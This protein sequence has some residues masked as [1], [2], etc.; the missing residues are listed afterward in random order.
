MIAHFSHPPQPACCAIAQQDPGIW[1]LWRFF[2]P[3]NHTKR[4]YRNVTCKLLNLFEVWA[5]GSISKNSHIAWTTRP[6]FK[7][8]DVCTIRSGRSIYHNQS[9]SERLT[10][11]NTVTCTNNACKLLNLSLTI[12]HIWMMLNTLLIFDLVFHSQQ[13]RIKYCTFTLVILLNQ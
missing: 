3:L 4:T 9:I 2:W 7:F 10:N 12:A 13:T 5:G 11:D 1:R 6:F 8:Q